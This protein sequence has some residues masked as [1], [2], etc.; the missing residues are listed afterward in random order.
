MIV[1]K[2]ESKGTMKGK[3]EQEQEQKIAMVKR[4]T[5]SDDDRD[6]TRRMGAVDG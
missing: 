4:A 6:N 5:L 2:S 3:E 1:E